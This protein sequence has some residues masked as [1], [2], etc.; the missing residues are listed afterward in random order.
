MKLDLDLA[1]KY[2]RP[3]PR[4]TSYPT[5][6]QFSEAVGADHYRQE[7]TDPDVPV[8][9]ELS[10]YF[11][12]PFCPSLCT[13]CACSVIITSRRDSIADYLR[14]LKL[15]V[16]LLASYLGSERRVGQ[17]HW[18]GGTPTYLTADEI[19][20]LMAHIRRR[21]EFSPEAEVSVEI[22]P[23]EMTEDRAMALADAGFN[24][25]SCGLQDFDERVQQTINRIQPYQLT[26]DVLDMLRQAGFDDINLDLIYGLPHQ[27]LASFAH[28]LEQVLTLNPRRLAVYNYAHVPWLKK[29]QKLI[30]DEW[31]PG[32][33]LKLELL[34]HIIDYLT[35]DG[36]MVFIGMDHF[37]QPDDEL[38]VALENGSLHRNF[39]C[40]STQAGLDMYALGITGIGKTHNYYLQ[41]HKQLST[42][43]KL[44]E[45]SRL[46]TQR[47]LLLTSDDHLRQRVIQ[48][49]MCRFELDVPAIEAEFN[50]EFGRY[51]DAELAALKPFEDDRLLQAGAHRLSIT[52][53]GRMFIR[54]IAMVFDAYLPSNGD[55]VPADEAAAPRYSNTV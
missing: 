52:E 22:D 13:F 12:L 2:S 17:L 28:T 45:D 6:P 23:R 55:A 29:H 5:A 38:A 54:N 21:F 30:K 15:E 41:N 27:S 49:I 53:K 51:F 50:I 14:V 9:P 16:D 35:T 11:H 44:V 8:T 3:G 40:Y 33:D 39:Q 46:P 18:G 24:R 48:D 10:L 20:S 43:K 36:N 25:V 37:A 32:P 42:Y 19:R 1:R 26:S 34:A 47:G 7:L 31:L 4:Y